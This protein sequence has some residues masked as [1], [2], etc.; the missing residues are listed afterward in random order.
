MSVTP[1]AR[2]EASEGHWPATGCPTDGYLRAAL[3]V[4]GVDPR[5]MT[6]DKMMSEARQQGLDFVDKQQPGKP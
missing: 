1:R 2:V 6:R 4:L 3:R 5:G